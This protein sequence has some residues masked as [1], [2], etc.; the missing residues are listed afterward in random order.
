MCDGVGS[1]YGYGAGDGYGDGYGYGAGDGYGAGYGY[2]YGD[3]LWLWA[4]LT[5]ARLAARGAQSISINNAVC[6]VQHVSD[7]SL[8]APLDCTVQTCGGLYG[9][10]KTR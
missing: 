5:I 6:C 1:G 4:T 9:V 10:H 2:G 8:Q 3:E 7:T